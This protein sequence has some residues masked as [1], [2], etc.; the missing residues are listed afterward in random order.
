[1]DDEDM[2]E[3]FQ[4]FTLPSRISLKDNPTDKCKEDIN[5][6][7]QTEW[8]DED[9]EH[10]IYI[11]RHSRMD[12]YLADDLMD[13]I[14]SNE[15]MVKWIGS[16]N[17]N[18]GMGWRPDPRYMKEKYI[19]LYPVRNWVDVK[20]LKKVLKSNKREFVAKKTEKARLGNQRGSFGVSEKHAQEEEQLW[21]LVEKKEERVKHNFLDKL[22]K[23]KGIKLKGGNGG[24]DC[25]I[26][27][28]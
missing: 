27:T 19:P 23:E 6:I 9:L 28:I 8:K 10:L 14:K 1:M 11:K 21:T 24:G 5:I 17:N 15:P 2:K 20:S 25:N 7:S 13:Y 16:E 4:T 22:A 18:T 12:C 26:C 3:L